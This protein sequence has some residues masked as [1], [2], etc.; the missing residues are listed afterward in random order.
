MVVGAVA[1]ATSVRRIMSDGEEGEAFLMGQ[2]ARRAN[3]G[4]RYVCC[5]YVSC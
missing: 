2:R 4:N 5:G 3:A 1:I